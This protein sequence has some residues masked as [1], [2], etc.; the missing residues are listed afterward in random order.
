MSQVRVLG[1]FGDEVGPERLSHGVVLL[2]LLRSLGFIHI[3]DALFQGRVA[4]RTAKP[5]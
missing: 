3:Y 1:N 2:R 5:S 4:G